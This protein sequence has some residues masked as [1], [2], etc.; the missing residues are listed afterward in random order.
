MHR[1]EGKKTKAASRPIRADDPTCS[2][3][4]EVSEG[5]LRRFERLLH[6]AE[7]RCCGLQSTRPSHWGCHR[8]RG[9]TITRRHSSSSRRRVGIGVGSTVGGVAA[10]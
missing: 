8:H 10:I 7:Q 6:A 2:P 4:E 3:C 5:L 1:V 9:A